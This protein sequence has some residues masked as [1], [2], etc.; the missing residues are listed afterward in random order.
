[1]TNVDQISEGIYRISTFNEAI[2]F[3]FNQFVI[4]DE[5]LTLVHTGSAQQFPATLQAMR[6]IIDPAQIRY[7]VISHF[8]SDECGALTKFLQTAANAVPVCSAVSARQL[9]GFDICTNAE[10]KHPGDTLDLGT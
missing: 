1:M 4:K 10:V 8:E 9:S 3:S 2:G 7:I 6:T 5:R